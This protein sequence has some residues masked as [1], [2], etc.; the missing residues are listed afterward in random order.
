[1][2]TMSLAAAQ[3][4]LSRLKRAPVSAEAYLDVLNRAIGSST[5]VDGVENMVERSTI[6]HGINE[7]A[8]ILGQN[9]V[10]TRTTGHSVVFYEM[11]RASRRS[12]R[13]GPT[14]GTASIDFSRRALHVLKPLTSLISNVPG[15]PTPRLSI[16][17]INRP[18]VA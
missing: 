5:R 15:S 1:M 11:E 17:L 18:A 9:F 10:A 6:F 14:R 3:M 4:E 7:A 8:F 13:Y 12:V 2:A 16:S